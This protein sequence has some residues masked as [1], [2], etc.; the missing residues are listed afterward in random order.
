[1][2]RVALALA[3]LLSA[4]APPPTQIVVVVDTDL[5]VPAD[6]DALAIDVTAPSG[7]VTHAA[8]PLGDGQPPLP[9][10]LVLFYEGGSLGP[11]AVVAAATHTGAP[12]IQTE[13]SIS[14]VP[15]QTL[16]LHVLLAG[17][18]RGAS[19]PPSM[20][21]GDDG[22][23][24]SPMATPCDVDP[25]SCTDAG[26]RDAGAD[27]G[28]SSDAAVDAAPDAAADAGPPC[29]L[30]ADARVCG[31]WGPLLAPGDRVTP[32]PCTAL[33][34]GVTVSY[35]LRGP[36]GTLPAASAW[37][38]SAVGDYQLIASASAPMG[39]SVSSSFHVQ[40]FDNAPTT[41][42][43]VG[44]HNGLDARVGMAFVADHT[45]PYAVTRT[46]GWRDLRTGATGSSFSNTDLTGVGVHL[47]DVLFATT[48]S[49]P[50]ATRAT[51][52]PDFS[53]VTLTDVP[54]PSPATDRSTRA[55]AFAIG[56]TASSAGPGAMA[57]RTGVLAVEDVP[58]A[59]TTRALVPA[60]DAA[61][62]VAVATTETST[63]G[64]VWS[65]D[66]TTLHNHVLGAGVAVAAGAPI[67]LGVVSAR[68]LAVDDR[69]PTAMRLALCSLDAG[70][71]IYD[72]A[73]IGAAL[74][75]PIATVGGAC[76]DVEV[77]VDGSFWMAT[78]TGLVRVD[79]SGADRARPSSAEGAPVA[80][81]ARLAIAWDATGREIWALDDL[82]GVYVVSVSAP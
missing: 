49:H 81:V 34:G 25:A 37:N 74:P 35:E 69:D 71:R 24:R 8:A 68:A 21:C 62:D 18:C 80:G 11:V 2:K 36:T 55:I 5:A 31:S 52:A 43:P 63:R 59:F 77:D 65:I 28:I 42:R 73:A 44:P 82:G 27:L 32:A 51:V 53:T 58:S 29:T 57:T 70:L 60:Y 78:A 67:P 10:R 6:V 1:M 48:A 26:P 22:S 19:C 33:P 17:A 12:V 13:R 64:A 47:G 54:Y 15:A 40:R 3:L 30:A 7:R 66:A 14:F 56:A 50:P 45:G 75:A 4:C 38:V 46:G 20:T 16:T 61:S 41:G 79:A 9:R 76:R 23:C 39:C 72:L